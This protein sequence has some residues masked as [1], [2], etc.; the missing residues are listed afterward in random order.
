M[1]HDED[2]SEHSTTEEIATCFGRYFAKKCSLGGEGDFTETNI[3]HFPARCTSTL[4]SVRFRQ[5]TVERTLRQLD[6]S[7]ATGPDEIP[8]RV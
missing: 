6:P 8:S 4:G 3:P 5:S 1:I 2:G 7:K